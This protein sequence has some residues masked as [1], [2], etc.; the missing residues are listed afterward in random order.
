MDFYS[1]QMRK[2]IDNKQNEKLLKPNQPMSTGTT[3]D[4]EY[5]LWFIAQVVLGIQVM[6]KQLQ[7]NCPEKADFKLLIIFLNEDNSKC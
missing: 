5:G 3:I 7:R 2:N 4:L 1:A 6:D